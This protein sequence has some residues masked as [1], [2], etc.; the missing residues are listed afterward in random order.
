MTM[1]R[2]RGET[3]NQILLVESCVGLVNQQQKLFSRQDLIRLILPLIVEQILAVT[4]GMADVIMVSSAGEAAVSGVSLVDMINVLIL[5]VFAALATGGAV[6]SSQFLGMR[7]RKKACQSAGHLLLTTLVISV[8]MAAAVLLLREPLL[9][10]LFGAIDPDV[11]RAALTYMTISAVSYPFIAVYNACAALFRSMGNSK[12]SMYTSL[13]MNLLNIAGNAVFVFGFH[14]GVA[15]VALSSLL[16]RVTAAVFILL[17]LRSPHNVIH[18]ATHRKFH[19][20]FALVRKILHIGIP[21][22]LENSLFQLGRV[23]VVGIIAGFGTVQIAANAVA[24]NLDAFGVI[25]GQAVSLAM[26]TVVG[27]CVGARDYGQAKAYAKKLL[28]IS[29]LVMAALDLAIVLCLPLILKLYNLSADTL[30]LATVLIAIHNLSAILLWP[31]SF[32]LPNALRAANDVRYTL[33]VALVSMAVLRILFSWILGDLLGM[34]A[35]G[36]WI[37]MV[38]DWTFRAVCFVWR[39]AGGRW[40]QHKI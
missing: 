6:V 30:E 7:R 32:T 23:L 39:F 22:A 16:S 35:I 15:G 19:F 18:L 2:A 8:G 28:K 17:L 12:I 31:A 11:M 26:I 33:V 14:C 13:W 1:F 20:D 25:P 27:R 38:A 40:Q 24:N 21:N 5:N 4:V 9:R 3:D 37:A 36:V 29:Y 34:G 10:L